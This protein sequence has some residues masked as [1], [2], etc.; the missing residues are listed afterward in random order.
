MAIDAKT[1]NEI[2]WSWL[3]GFTDGDGSIYI[4]KSGPVRIKWGQKADNEWLLERI[5]VFLISEGIMATPLR[6]SVVS[7]GHS[8]PQSVLAIGAQETVRVVLE[9]LLPFLVLK[10]EAALRGLAAL[11]EMD[12][13]K[14]KNGRYWRKPNSGGWHPDGPRRKELTSGSR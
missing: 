5:S 4:L 2:S 10:R 11:R 1:Q 8:Y 12:D 13:L 14:K 7:A 6:T 9:R 3:S